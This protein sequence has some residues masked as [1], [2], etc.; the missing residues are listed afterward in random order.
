MSVKLWI[1]V[2]E[3]IHLGGELADPD[4]SGTLG[5]LQARV[6]LIKTRYVNALDLNQENR[7]AADVNELFDFE[8]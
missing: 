4:S 3:V 6:S 5:G 1:N 2:E 7:T 8:R